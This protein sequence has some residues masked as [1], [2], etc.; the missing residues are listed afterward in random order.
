MTVI[1]FDGKYIDDPIHTNP[2]REHLLEMIER[3]DCEIL[4]VD[5]LDVGV[6]S[7]WVLGILAAIQRSG[8]QVEL[9][10]PSKEMQ[11]VLEVTNLSNYLHVRGAVS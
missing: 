4:V 7:S 11:D 8:V 3:S 2:I 9:Y 5:M 10:H 1:G 6:V